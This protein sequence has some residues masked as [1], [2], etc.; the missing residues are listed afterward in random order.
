M[1]NITTL[2]FKILFYCISYSRFLLVIYFIHIGVYMSIPISQFNP[3]P[4]P[5]PPAPTFPL[6][7][8]TFVL[9]ICVSFLPCKPVHLYHISRFHIY[10]LIHDICL[11]LS[12][13]LHY[14]WQSIS[15]STSLQMTQFHSFLWLNNIPLYTC[16]T[17]LSIC[18]SMDI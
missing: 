17:S 10:A 9:Y 13:L 16:S 4:P 18:L 3:A 12:D 2:I 11:S 6:G 5:P 1:H 8:Q 15:P 7:V 14:V